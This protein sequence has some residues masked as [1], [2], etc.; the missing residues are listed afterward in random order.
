MRG[1]PTVAAH[2]AAN[3]DVKWKSSL[4]AGSGNEILNG[5][6]GHPAFVDGTCER[7]SCTCGRALVDGRL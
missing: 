1:E 7:V 2:R 4:A 5:R 3:G 6:C